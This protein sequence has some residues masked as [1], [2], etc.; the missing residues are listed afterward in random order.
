MSL[1]PIRYAGL[2][3]FSFR[4]LDELN[5]VAKGTSF[6]AFKAASPRLCEGQDYFYLSSAEHRQW[7]ES[8]KVSGQVYATSVHLVLITQR[9]Y[10]QMRSSGDKA[11]AAE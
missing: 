11:E 7:I 9:G 6:R 5:D 8:L 2:N 4:Q 10:A 3:T 1:V